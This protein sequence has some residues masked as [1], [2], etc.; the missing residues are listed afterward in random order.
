[1]FAHTKPIDTTATVFGRL[2]AARDAAEPS[3]RSAQR[4]ARRPETGGVLGKET[5]SAS[6]ASETLNPDVLFSQRSRRYK[7]QRTA[8]S[9]LQEEIPRLCQCGVRMRAGVTEVRVHQGDQG[10]YVKGLRRCGNV[11]CCP[12][13][14]ARIAQ[15]R[16]LEAITALSSWRAEGG[17]V[18][19]LT[20]TLPHQR[21]DSLDQVLTALRKCAKYLNSGRGAIKG[22]LANYGYIGQV[23]SQEVTHGANGWHPHLHVLVFTQDDVPEHVQDAIKA[24]WEAAAIANGWAAP[25]WSVGA[26]W[27]DGRHAAEYVNKQGT[28]GM[29]EEVTMS[30]AKRGNGGRTPFELLQDAALDDRQAAALFTEYA[31]AVKGTRQQFWTPGLKARFAIAD[32]TDEEIVDQDDVQPDDVSPALDLDQEEPCI[33]VV[34]ADDWFVVVRYEQRAELL[35]AAEVGGQL[36]VDFLCKLLH[37]RRKSEIECKLANR[38]KITS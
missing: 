2:S 33:A 5:K 14:A 13:C 20:L 24:R 23:R 29:A 15:T 19:M 31:R 28:W 38:K 11:H 10:A 37:E 21:W 18:S 27:R 25:N 16:R 12:V 22:L 34:Q 4:D 8:G 30:T 9:L 1:M 3:A 36:A 6:T 26:D 17:T 35:R 32:V 7:L